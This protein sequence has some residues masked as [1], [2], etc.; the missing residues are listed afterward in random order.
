MRENKMICETC[1][2]YDGYGCTRSPIVRDGEERCRCDEEGDNMNG[3]TLDDYQLLA[4]RTINAKLD[5]GDQ[6]AHTLHGLVAE[7]GELHGIFQKSYQ[8]HEIDPDHVRK[9]VGDILWMVAEFCT[10]NG[11]LLGNIAGLNIEK[12][13][14]RY[15]D[16]F[17]PEHCLH[18]AEGD[19]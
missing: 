18:R 15:P 6:A 19:V 4:A 7:V 9:E 17:D 5:K 11:W 16:G 10:A 2:Y 12:L 1:G 14:A 3:L 8:G 13:K